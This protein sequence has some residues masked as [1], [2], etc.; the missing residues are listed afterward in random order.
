MP[1]T[2]RRAFLSATILAGPLA[3]L[4]LA[5]HAQTS[6]PSAP[7]IGA[8]DIGGT[9]ASAQGPEA[10]VW[11]IAETTGLPTKGSARNNRSF[12]ILLKLWQRI[13]V[14]TAQVAPVR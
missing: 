9:V 12:L 14:V 6:P 13:I 11:V 2:A 10:G 7:S 1:C 5:A 3:L 8:A 4:P